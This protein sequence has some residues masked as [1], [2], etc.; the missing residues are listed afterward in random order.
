MNLNDLCQSVAAKPARHR[1]G[2]GCGS[3]WG[4]T[5]KRGHKG[6]HSRS[7]WRRKDHYEGGQTPAIRRLPKRGFTNAQF[8]KQL[9]IVNLEKLNIFEDGTTV[10]PELLLTQ[11]IVL[12]LGDGLKVLGKGELERKLIVKAH[13]ISEKARAAIEAKGGSV[14]LIPLRRDDALASIKSKRF[15][16]KRR[17]RQIR[18]GKVVHRGRKR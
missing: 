13:R 3:G 4:K 11:R 5:S 18:A 14:E 15:K 2:R 9:A 6:A 10:T 16:G 17:Q 1:V 7:G 12:D 8:M